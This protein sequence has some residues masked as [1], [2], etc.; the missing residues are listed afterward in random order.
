MEHTVLRANT[1][2]SVVCQL[3]LPVVSS[4]APAL[5]FTAVRRRQPRARSV[6]IGIAEGRLPLALSLAGFSA[7]QM[8]RIKKGRLL[9]FGFAIYGAVLIALAFAPTFR[10]AVILFAI[11]GVV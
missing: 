6:A 2:V 3:S 7:P 8:T 9:L 10:L 1:V 4:L 11:G 5:I